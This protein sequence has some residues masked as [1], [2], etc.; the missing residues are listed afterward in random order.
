MEPQR[1]QNPGFKIMNFMW[2]VLIAMAPV[3]SLAQ[4]IN[5][6]QEAKSPRAA[7]L[8]SVVVPGWG[9]H[10][11]DNTNWTRGQYHLAADAVM[12]LSFAGIKL[13]V[14]NLETNIETFARSNAGIDLSG[15]SRDIF[16]AVGNFDNLAEYNDY[17]LR[18]RN[19]DNLIQDK[20]ENRWNW[21]E[22]EQRFDYNDMRTRIDKNNNQLPGIITLMVAN[23]LVSGISAFV[24]ARNHNANIPEASF[25][26]LNEFGEPGFTARLSYS[27]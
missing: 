22:D 24:R 12:I 16:L 3:F 15:R 9:H 10:Y 2:L 14:N 21:P 4:N 17:Q 19:W 26:Y 5:T 23:R 18:T 20:P 27:F 8:R 25:S 13:R 1:I 6:Q 7:F 11:L